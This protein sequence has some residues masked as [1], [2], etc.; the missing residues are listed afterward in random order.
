MDINIVI[1][2][3]RIRAARKMKHMS[4]DALAEKI[5]IAAESLG[6]IECGSRK[7][8]LQTLYAIAETLEVSLDYL[9][10]RTVSPAEAAVQACL[11]EYGLTPEQEKLL[12]DLTKS[13][14]PIIKDKI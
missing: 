10:G 8:S 13:M 3:Q 12:K 7:P 11:P 1:M 4:A 6:H 14:I 9:I 5:G 2:G